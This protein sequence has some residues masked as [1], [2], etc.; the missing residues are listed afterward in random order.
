MA[1]YVASAAA[2]AVMLLW[3]L[4]R[5]VSYAVAPEGFVVRAPP[6]I[7]FVAVILSMFA[8]KVAA[9]WSLRR[10]AMRDAQ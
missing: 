7:V 3:L 9:N 8:M 6:T 4:L 1:F 5:I 2:S 10:D